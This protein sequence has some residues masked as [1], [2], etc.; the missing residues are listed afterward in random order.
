MYD[1][2]MTAKRCFS[3]AT[4]FLTVVVIEL[5]KD[6]FFSF[7]F[8]LF[9]SVFIVLGLIFRAKAKKDDE[10]AK[11]EN[12]ENTE[13]NNDID[14]IENIENA[15]ENDD[16]QQSENIDEENNISNFGQ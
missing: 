4:C 5:F 16:S 15:K 13:A 1:N 14:Q 7:P 12:S 9:G 3:A 11:L 8:A 10:K 6:K 2:K